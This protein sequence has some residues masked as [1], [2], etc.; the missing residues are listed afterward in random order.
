MRTLLLDVPHVGSTHPTTVHVGP[1][2]LVPLLPLV[3]LV[4]GAFLGVLALVVSLC[5]YRMGDVLPEVAVVVV[6]GGAAVLAAIGA[7]R[8]SGPPRTVSTLI[9]GGIG[10]NALGDVVYL[11]DA[12]RRTVPDASPADVLYLLS[13]LLLVAA[14]FYA[15]VDGRE[16]RGETDAVVDT[17]TVVV[18]SVLLLLEL[19]HHLGGDTDGSG[20]L[21]HAVLTAYP[22]LDAVV[23]GLLLRAMATRRD[24]VGGWLSVGLGVWLVADLTVLLAG[25]SSDA[26][27]VNLCW[28]LG[29]VAMAQ[30]AWQVRVGPVVSRP[31][32]EVSVM[33]AMLA[34]VPLTIP[35]ALLV[36]H[37]PDSPTM[38]VATLLATVLLAVLAV[39]RTVRQVR[40]EA[41]ARRAAVAAD[42]AK[43]EFLATMS[44]EI[45]TPMNGVLGLS[46]LLLATGL[47]RRQRQYAEGVHET[48]QALLAIIN[49]LLDFAKIEA[50]RVEIDLVETDLDGLLRD[51]ATLV[52]TPDRADEVRV[53]VS[54]DVPPVLADAGHL[55]QV[56]LNLAANAVKF[57]PQ[58]EVRL[59]AS[60][61]GLD[62]AAGDVL[63]VRVEVTDD[64]I[65][66]EPDQLDQVFEPFAQ[67]D[68]STT[69]RFGGTGLGLSI[70]RQL[71]DAMGGTLR[72][73]ST[74]GSGSRFWFT[75]DLEPVRRPAP[76]RV[77]VL[78]DGDVNQLVAE[79][80][81]EHLGH[82]VVTDRGQDHDVVLTPTTGRAR[83]TA[84]A[85]T[86]PV[87]EV[88]RPLVPADLDA[89]LRRAA[90]Q[91]AET[92][93][94]N[95]RPSSTDR[96][97]QP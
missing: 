5:W 73:E 62:A 33:R 29:C 75:L 86:A 20:P 25:V 43:S 82:T 7:G 91:P 83:P 59:S 1:R 18:V 77:L 6:N 65:G 10:V 11:W 93:T 69:R 16:R 81:V 26:A 45:R 60:V 21:G 84:Y 4:P 28:M 41:E 49:D 3:P 96:P 22:V 55:R 34:I 42:R 15:A 50:G 74:P 68:V 66:I 70:S 38:R 54:C 58:G 56:L 19:Q 87:V 64:G 94:A 89:A 90:S 47:D 35:T 2:R 78:E 72:A 12:T 17:L 85:G 48:G 13:M 8:L 57:T 51:V 46:S 76:V 67:A 14:L 80:I 92:R 63:R 44:H 97:P 71:V 79:G 37:R 95:G 36:V 88:G 31:R 24:L 23:L 40:A 39:I 52:V 61:V 53:R 9:A 27:L 32:R 30:A